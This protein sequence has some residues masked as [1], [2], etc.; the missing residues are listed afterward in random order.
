MNALQGKIMVAATVVV[1]SA[2]LAKQ[3][4]AGGAWSG[5]WVTEVQLVVPMAIA[6]W[7]FARD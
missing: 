6:W 3:A 5:F 4:M 7:V 1:M 2:L